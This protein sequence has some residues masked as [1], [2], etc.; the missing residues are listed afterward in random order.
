MRL[1]PVD[2]FEMD[3]PPGDDSEEP[4]PLR[5]GM[6]GPALRDEENE[7]LEGLLRI[8]GQP[9]LRLKANLSFGSAWSSN[10][11]LDPR[12]A[13]GRVKAISTSVKLHFDSRQ[14][15][16]KFW[17]RGRGVN[18]KTTFD[19]EFHEPLIVIY[20][21]NRQLGK[22]NVRTGDLDDP[23]AAS[24]LSDVTELY[25]VEEILRDLH[26]ASLEKGRKSRQHEYLRK[27]KVILA[28]TLP[29]I[30]PKDIQIFAPDI[31]DRPWE[32]SGVCVKTFSGLVPISHLSLG[33]RTTL[34]WVVDFGWRLLKRY[35][36]SPNALAEPAVV[37]ID[38]LDLHLHPLWQ[39]TI[40]DDLSAL[41][42]ATQFI[43]TAHSPLIVQVAETGNFAL[44]R[45]RDSDV[46]I[47][48]DP[49]IVRTWRVD[50]ILTSHLF[51]VPRARNKA[52]DKLFEE[53][54]RLLDKPS[55]SPAEEAKLEGLQEQISKLP[56]AQDPDD[57]K[58]MD[59]IR[60]TAALLK[61]QKAKG[62]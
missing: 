17:R 20:G 19:G 53:R 51:K 37:L 30:S 60:E 21:A 55:R 40:M 38:E 46:E 56:T 45:K 27:L 5:K 2:K 42:P 52:T 58:A 16:S 8:G 35:P 1:V 9:E 13:P 25:D 7:M 43:A 3:S 62:Q 49:E 22:L 15:L 12:T 26:H 18:I 29:D 11:E 44:L 47:A 10:S 4:P 6:L 54:D 36:T 50:Q 57:Q 48:N 23:A 61:R 24:R 32:P 14:R 34:A 33:Y 28:R 59:F 31:L 39:L 41:F